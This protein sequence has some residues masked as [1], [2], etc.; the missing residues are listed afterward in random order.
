[1][2]KES[3]FAGYDSVFATRLRALMEHSKTTQQ[4]LAK[5]TNITRQAIAQYADGSVQPNIEKLYKIAE[6]FKVSADYLLGR[7]NE[8]TTDTTVQGIHK[9]TGL[10]QDAIGQLKHMK[11]GLALP[12]SSTLETYLLNKML[13]GSTSWLGLHVLNQM[14]E[15]VFADF[16]DFHKGKI[17]ITKSAYNTLGEKMPAPTIE[18]T[19]FANETDFLALYMMRVQTAILN[20][21]NYLKHNE[22]QSNSGDE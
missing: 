16:D 22:K 3:K 18:E 13:D 1:M 11:D 4:E 12:E 2:N 20:F 15:Y 21:R 8:P 10:N 7:T 5:V 6:H 19:Y 9:Y 14:S 17:E